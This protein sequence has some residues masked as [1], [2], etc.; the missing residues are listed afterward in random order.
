MLEL[1]EIDDCGLQPAAT[2]AIATKA[3][4]MFRSY[5]IS[6]SSI[7]CKSFHF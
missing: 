1:L 3:I 5:R 6:V 7:V 2:T 4:Q